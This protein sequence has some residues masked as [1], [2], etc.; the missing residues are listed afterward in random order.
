M[1][2]K[3]KKLFKTQLEEIENIGK[4]KYKFNITNLTNKDIKSLFNNFTVDE[5]LEYFYDSEPDYD[6][7]EFKM[8]MDYLYQNQEI[9][10][11]GTSFFYTCL[12]LDNIHDKQENFRFSEKE[13][14]LEELKQAHEKIEKERKNFENIRLN[15][16]NWVEL[17]HNGNWGATQEEVQEYGKEM[18]L[19]LAKKHRKNRW[20][21]AEN[22]KNVY[23][24]FYGRDLKLK[25][26][27]L[28]VFNKE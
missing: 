20:A 25:C 21:K 17:H 4:N 13:H 24:Y 23:I 16:N 19:A 12:N 1:N 9:E 6:E 10:P 8:H 27:Y 7:E 14:T 22:D 5:W 11:S 28:F 3:N 2:N 18:A 26:D 15:F